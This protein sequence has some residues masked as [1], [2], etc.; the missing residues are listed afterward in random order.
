MVTGRS[1]SPHLMRVLASAREKPTVMTGVGELV[2]R[3]HRDSP[4]APGWSSP[5]TMGAKHAVR[6]PRQ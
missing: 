2:S 1:V 6:L 5:W 3:V 4:V